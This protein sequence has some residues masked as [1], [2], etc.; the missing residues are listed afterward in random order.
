MKLR[1]PS[2]RRSE[3]GLCE[4]GSD[5]LARVRRGHET[6]VRGGPIGTTVSVRL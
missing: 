1:V 5:E 3:T 6:R 4:I 2:Q